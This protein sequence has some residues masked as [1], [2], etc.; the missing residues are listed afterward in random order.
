[1]KS[2]N[3]N[4][5]AKWPCLDDYHNTQVKGKYLASLFNHLSI[6]KNI[7]QNVRK[8]EIDRKM[9]QRQQQ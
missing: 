4:V 5:E 9:L 8:N 2:G 6:L 1:M 7:H 3:T